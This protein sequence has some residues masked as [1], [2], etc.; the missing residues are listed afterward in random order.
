MKGNA[1]ID[2]ALSKG[3]SC[4]ELL[5]DIGNCVPLKRF[6]G[7]L[8]PLVD[9]ISEDHLDYLLI[10]NRVHV[11]G[12][13]NLDAPVPSSFMPGPD[14]C[15]F[16]QNL[17]QWLNTQKRSNVLT[18]GYKDT[19]SGFNNLYGSLLET[20][21]NAKG[22][23]QVYEFIGPSLFFN[24]IV[25]GYGFVSSKEGFIQVFGPFQPVWLS[26]PKEFGKHL[27]C[28]HYWSSVAVRDNLELFRGMTAQSLTI[29]IF[30]INSSNVPKSL[31]PFRKIAG[32][33]L[34]NDKKLAYGSIMRQFK[35]RNNF[36][37]KGNF[38]YAYAQPNLV[39]CVIVIIDKLF[40]SESWGCSENRLMIIQKVREI[41][42]LNS[43]HLW[44]KGTLNLKLSCKSWFGKS[45]NLTS[46]QDYNARKSTIFAFVTWI[47][48]FALPLIIRSLWHVT[49]VSHSSELLYI[50][51]HKWSKMT[52]SWIQNYINYNLISVPKSELELPTRRKFVYGYFRL[53]PKMNDFR[54]I[55]IPVKLAGIPGSDNKDNSKNSIDY[56]IYYSHFVNPI[57]KVLGFKTDAYFNHPRCRSLTDVAKHIRSFASVNPSSKYYF[58]KFDMKQCYDRIDQQKIL[59]SVKRI[60]ARDNFD[61][62]YYV[63]QYTQL[64]KRLKVRKVYFRVYDDLAVILNGMETE[65]K[66]HKKVII[67]RCK[68][69]KITKQEILDMVALQV[70]GSVC[71]VPHLDSYYKRK[72]G[73]FQGFP[74]LATLC[75]IVYCMMMEDKFAFA[76]SDPGSAI[77]RIADDFMLVTEKLSIYN[78]CLEVI[79][80]QELLDYGAIAN[81][82]KTVRVLPTD[83]TAELQFVGLSINTKTLQI[84]LDCGVPISLQGL[85]NFKTATRLLRSRF[86]SGLSGFYLNVSLVSAESV[87]GYLESLLNNVLL[88]VLNNFRQFKSTLTVDLF[89]EF[90]IG[91]FDETLQALEVINHGCFQYVDEVIE[92][93]KKGIYPLNTC[94][95]ISTLINLLN[96]L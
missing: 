78:R 95:N 82:E 62:S 57:L 40:P 67:D 15:C 13:V 5:V 7:P 76:L 2:T 34:S 58:L 68:T 11:A 39:A 72:Q 16:I 81:L 87:I 66:L 17:I 77:L 22:F 92:L 48:N 60:F 55:C 90:I 10:I 85:Q 71:Y 38:A 61:K 30:D 49:E 21:L 37:G 75:D 9:L 79:N 29:R 88:P 93:F 86:K 80:G 8:L 44:I 45:E 19:D 69:Y 14:Y 18:N 70:H 3:S 89:L 42:E 63:R 74:L 56:Q 1:S 35:L 6:L 31:R 43:P 36:V 4:D 46:R 32:R 52:S 94:I 83:D 25:S 33:I 23:R 64:S 73:I 12:D 59:E 65:I 20:L 54:L 96:S 91:L 53:I 28:L 50:P 27:P 41:I 24:L 84:K 26:N 51:Q 47:L